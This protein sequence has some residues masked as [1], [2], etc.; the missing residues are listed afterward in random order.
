[1]LIHA[2]AGHNRALVD[3]H[4]INCV[5]HVSDTNVDKG[6]LIIASLF[7]KDTSTHT[8][9]IRNFS[10]QY[11]GNTTTNCDLLHA[12]HLS[13]KWQ[14]L[15]LLPLA[16]EHEY[17][18]ILHDIHHKT[19]A[20]I[21]WVQ[22]ELG[23]RRRQ[24]KT[25]RSYQNTWN[26]RA[27]FLIVVDEILLDPRHTAE[28]ILKEVAHFKVFNV[29]VVIPSNGS[30]RAFDV[31]T[32]FPY[33]LPSGQCGNFKNSILVDQWIM[34]GKGRFLRNVSLFPPKIPR[35]F[36]GC[37]ITAAL[38][39][40]KPFVMSLNREA[41]KENFTVYNE[42]SDIRLFLFVAEVMNMSVTVTPSVNVKEIWPVKLENGSWTGVL[43]E[44]FDKEADI[45]FSG[46]SI[47]LDRYIHFDV[48]KVYYFS[49]LLWI[50]PCAEPFEGWYSITRVFS[51][52]LW[53]LIFIMIFLSAGFM[54][55][56]SKY[57]PQF[58]EAVDSYRNISNCFYNVWAI[59]LGTSVPN[60]PVTDHLKFFFVILVWYSL[61]INTVFQAFVTSYLIDPGFHKQ[62]SSLED[63]IASGIEYGYYPGLDVLLPKKSDWRFKEIT[64]HRIP[65]YNESCAERAVVKKDF[66]TLTDTMYTEYMKTYA[67][68]DSYGRPAVC[69]F[70]Q[71]SKVRPVAMYLKKG[72]FL[73][74]NAN[75]AISIA[76]EAGLN[77][78]WWKNILHTLRNKAAAVAE[79]TLK[80]DYTVFLLDH[81]QGVFYLLALGHCLAFLTFTGELM[82]N[83]LHARTRLLKTTNHRN[84]LVPLRGGGGGRRNDWDKA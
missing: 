25:L 56:T 6:F 70:K 67:A 68:Y 18:N 7:S 11:C 60:M 54:Y 62:I 65:C 36:G 77:T 32:W 48:T 29:I 26:S 53:S 63:L 71:E 51:A 20:Y 28:E 45:A 23:Y 81:L 39:P 16:E 52:S 9:R 59:F 19:T 12:L 27:R 83:M 79:Q 72:S 15:T 66:A 73:T 4:L 22:N 33:E 76:I 42:G 38:I 84:N 37:K 14:I 61:A 64:S 47:N 50:V 80:D 49:G 58:I 24:L 8:R 13:K 10:Q 57:C 46:L 35:D 41:N 44:V 17:N 69:S 74:E 1:M 34:E 55:F 40:A 21:L 82:H 30:P 5:L 2:A 78:F 75:R 3:V 31:Y 43:G